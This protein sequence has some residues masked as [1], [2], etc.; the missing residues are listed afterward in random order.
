MDIKTLKTQLDIYQV[1]ERLNIPI[2]KYH[3]ALCPFHHDKT[4]SLQFSREKQI[5]TC[6]SSN[7]TAGTMDVINLTEK[8]LSL[9]THEA[10]KWLETEFNL[11][12][13]STPVVGEPQ[14]PAP[15]NYA[16]LFKVFAANLKKSSKGKAYLKERG[17]SESLEV[18]YNGTAWEK[19]KH[20]II[21]PLKNKKGEITSLY[22]RSTVNNAQSKHYYNSNRTGLY[23]G[24]PSPDTET[25]ILTESVIDA[26]TLSTYA[27]AAV[28][29]ANTAVLA[30]YG[31]NGLT[32][33]HLEAIKSLPGLKEIILFFDGDQAGRAAIEKHTKILSSIASAKEDFND[34]RQP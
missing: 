18:G 5:A 17:L 30:L 6:F 10:I 15:V 32:D 11:Q 9:S 23:P 3:K 12:Q 26:A 20:C 22:G 21:F 16:K 34:T 33:E 13:G 19:M 2:N 29:N 27:K 7:C 8:K 28:D 31:T 24:Y 25:L 14:K 4:P 1:A